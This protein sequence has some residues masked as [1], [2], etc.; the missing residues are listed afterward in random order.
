MRENNCIRGPYLSSKLQTLNSSGQK[1]AARAEASKWKYSFREFPLGWQESFRTMFE[2]W[3]EVFLWAS[4]QG[5]NTHVNRPIRRGEP[6]RVG[7]GERREC[8]DWGIEG[9]EEAL[10]SIHATSGNPD[11]RMLRFKGKVGER[12]VYALLDS[13][14]SHSFVYPAIL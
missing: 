9:V 11:L 10:L 3:R 4:M 1:K 14:S 5:A 12:Q 2:V 7:G 13:A 8:A 6:W